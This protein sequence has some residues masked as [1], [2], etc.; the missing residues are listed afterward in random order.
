MDPFVG[1]LENLT[2]RNKAYRH[3]LFTDVGKLQLVVMKL[4]PNEEIGR[5]IHNTTTQFIRIE[6]GDAIATIG[7]TPKPSSNDKI[8]NLS[9]NGQDT[10]IIPQGTYHNIKNKSKTKLLHLYTIYSPPEHP[11]QT[12]QKEKII[13]S[14]NGGEQGLSNKLLYNKLKIISRIEKN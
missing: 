7:T 8:F 2:T 12:Y 11:P 10:I 13:K 14:M 9:K 1:N 4:N 3:V 5:E 6:Q